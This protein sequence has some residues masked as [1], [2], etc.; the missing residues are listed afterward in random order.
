MSAIFERSSDAMEPLQ[1]SSSRLPT[2][3]LTGPSLRKSVS[4]PH[5]PSMDANGMEVYV[6]TL[7]IGFF[8]GLAAQLGRAFIGLSIYLLLCT[9]RL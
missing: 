7:F 4:V 1:T 5:L 6:S 3:F 2:S 8:P 9:N